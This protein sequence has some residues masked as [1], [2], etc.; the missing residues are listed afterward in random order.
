VTFPA[1]LE[2]TSMAQLKWN[3]SLVYYQCHVE[4]AQQFL[5]TASGEKL[6]GKVQKYTITEKFVVIAV[7]GSYRLKYFTSSLSDFPNKKF[8]YLKLL[9]KP[10]WNFKLEKDT[11]LSEHDVQIFSA[12]EDKSHDTTEY[13]FKVNKQNTNE[14]IIMGVKVMRQLVV[15]GGY[16]LKKNLE[17][18]R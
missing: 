2:N 9:E 17:A 13:D 7:N 16:L 5:V 14:I 18:L 4:E 3:D 8:A 12:M 1:H 11:V 10:Y 15:Q 6:A